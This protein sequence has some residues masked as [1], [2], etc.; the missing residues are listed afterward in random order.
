MYH[1]LADLEGNMPHN[2][3]TKSFRAYLLTILNVLIYRCTKV[4]KDRNWTRVWTLE[5]ELMIQDPRRQ[6]DKKVGVVPVFPWQ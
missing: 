4:G 5:N 2:L 1:I 3:W 6:R